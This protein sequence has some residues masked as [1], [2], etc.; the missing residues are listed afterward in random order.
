MRT[1]EIKSYPKNRSITAI[2]IIIP[3]EWDVQGNPV[4]VALSTNDE[5]EY[6]IDRRS[7]KGRE[8]AKLVREQVR[9][10]GNLNEKGS[11]IVKQYE[12]IDYGS[13]ETK[14]HFSENIIKLSLKPR[15]E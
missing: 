4:R 10:V 8:I 6:V 2:G 13:S 15:E 12:C 11:I 3:V 1:K 7:R 5:H 9:I 14:D